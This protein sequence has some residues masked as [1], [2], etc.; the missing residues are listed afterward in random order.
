MPANMPTPIERAG[1]TEVPVAAMEAKWT[2]VRV[3][4]MASGASG[5]VLAAG[6]GDGEDHADEERGH[7]RL[8]QEGGPPGV[9]AAGVAEGV[10]AEVPDT[11]EARE[12]VHEPPQHGAGDE[13][14]G[15]LDQAVQ[16]TA[17][18]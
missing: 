10:L 8:E 6:V 7:Q 4:P 3:R 13:R 5:R 12:A 9:A 17:A 1:F 11:A 14:T 2:T 15:E 16:T 18:P